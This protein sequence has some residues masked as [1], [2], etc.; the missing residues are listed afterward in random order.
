MES[1]VIVTQRTSPLSNFGS[2][3]HLIQKVAI[4]IDR[5]RSHNY[6]SCLSGEKLATNIKIAEVMAR[7]CIYNI[8]RSY[9]RN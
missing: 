4:T 6:T 3:A 7:K 8:T 9:E 5:S 2:E 1:N